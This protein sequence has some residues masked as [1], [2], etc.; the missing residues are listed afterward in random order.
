MRPALQAV[1]VEMVTVVIAPLEKARLYFKHRPLPGLVA[2]DP[3]AATHRKYGV[4]T[5]ERL[6]AM[7][8]PQYMTVMVNPMG[9]F[10]AALPL[11]EASA[12]LNRRDDY[13]RLPEDE[14]LHK[15]L[16][17]QLEGCFLLDRT[18]VVRWTHV[19]S[20]HG[21]QDHGSIPGEQEFLAAARRLAKEPSTT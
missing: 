6:H 20:M 9:E 14:A 17:S 4:P 21:P 19:E 15:R 2:V 7:T 16:G 18:G 1:G 3:E 13:R 11:A 5:G 12:E 10:P 8:L